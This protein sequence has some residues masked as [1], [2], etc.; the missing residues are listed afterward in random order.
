VR[1]DV[2]S[3]AEILARIERLQAS[4]IDEAR[5]RGNPWDQ[6]AVVRNL[7]VIGEASKRLS[8]AT[9]DLAPEVPWSR[10]AGFRDV[11]IHGYDRVDIGRVWSILQNDLPALKSSVRK[12]LVEIE[13]AG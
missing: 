8:K 5:L 1:S 9:R 11:A 7:E 10:L 4:G 2:P 12:L 6:D 13:P 3:L